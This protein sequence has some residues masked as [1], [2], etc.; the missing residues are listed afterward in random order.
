MV[1]AGLF[2]VG[3]LALHFLLNYHL[4]RVIGRTVRTIIDYKSGGIY[5]MTYHKIRI[6]LL[7]NRLEIRNLRFKPDTARYR[8]RKIH[9]FVKNGLFEI[10]IPQVEIEGINFF[11]ILFH[12]RL[13]IQNFH[14][15][16]PEISLLDYPN[17]R[18]REE[19]L[20]INNLYKF[21]S[22]YLNF[23]KIENLKIENGSFT[24]AYPKNIKKQLCKIDSISLIVRQFKVD[25]THQPQYSAKPFEVADIELAIQRNT[26]LFPESDYQISMGKFLLSTTKTFA[27]LSDIKFKSKEW[28]LAVP[29]LRVVGIDFHTLYYTKNLK[30]SKL[31]IKKPHFQ[32]YQRSTLGQVDISKK[33][34]KFTA[35]KNPYVL[36]SKFL[37]SL[38][39]VHILVEKG[40]FVLNL[41]RITTPKNVSILLERFYLDSLTENQRAKH[42]FIDEVSAQVGDYELLLSDNLHL[43][44]IK[45]MGFSTKTS[46]IYAK[47]V[48]LA[49]T[50]DAQTF[51]LPQQDIFDIAIPE[52]KIKAKN[53][54]DN[55]LT[56]SLVFEELKIKYPQIQVFK[57]INTENITS[58]I[59][60]QLPFYVR[61]ISLENA[62]LQYHQWKKTEEQEHSLDKILHIPNLSAQIYNLKLHEDKYFEHLTLTGENI[63]M[64]LPDLQQHLQIGNIN[65]SSVQQLLRISNFRYFPK[66]VTSKSLGTDSHLPDL[67]LESFDIH[68]FYKERSLKAKK[69]TLQRPSL[70][71]VSKIDTAILAGK[72]AKNLI[73]SIE[74]E[75][76]HLQNA[77]INLHKQSET[78]V[79][80]LFSSDDMSAKLKQVRVNFDTPTKAKS[81]KKLKKEALFDWTL[82]EGEVELNN[83]IFSFPDGSHIIKVKNIVLNYEE[84]TAELK[85]ISLLPTKPKQKDINLYR[86]EIPSIS[87][88][89]KDINHLMEDKNWI[90]NKL[91]I[92]KPQLDFSIQL[93]TAVKH[94][95]Q[96]KIREELKLNNLFAQLP[97]KKL[98][99]NQ[100]D[101]DSSMMVIS[102]KQANRK[103]S[104][105]AVEDFSLSLEHLEVDSAKHHWNQLFDLAHINLK[106]GAYRHFLADNIHQI[107]A[108]N[109][110][111]FSKD[112][113][114]TIHHFSINPIARIGIPYSIEAQ[115]KS[116]QIDI[117]TPYLHFK[118]W[119]LA[120][121]LED[122]ALNLDRA[123]IQTPQINLQVHRP[124]T[125]KK[126]KDFTQKLRA[127]SLHKMIAPFVNNLKIKDLKIINGDLQLITHHFQKTNIFNLDSISIHTQNFDIHPINYQLITQNE[128]NQ[129]LPPPF[130]FDPTPY[131]FLNAENIEIRL[132][133]YTFQLPDKIHTLKAKSIY[134]SIKDSLL[135]AENV[136]FVP[137]LDKNAF[138]KQRQFKT[139]WLFPKIQKLSLHKF[140]FY[141]LLHHEEL[142]MRNLEVDSVKFEIYR[143]RGLP[144]LPDYLPPMP[145]DLLRELPFFVKID[146]IKIKN[147]DI[148]Y[149][150]QLPAKSKAGRL[151]F[152]KTNIDLVSLTNHPDS[153]KSY[154]Y[155]PILKANTY[156]MGQGKLN[157]EARFFMSDPKNLHFLKGNIGEMDMR[158][159]NEMLEYVFPVRITSGFIRN[160][161]F[162]LKLNY[163]HAKGSM[164]L[165]YNDLKVEVI[166]RKFASFVANSFVVTNHNPAR[167]FVPLR[168]GEIKTR[169]N[170][171]RSIFSYWGYSVLNGF[172]TSIG[173]RGKKQ[174]KKTKI[175]KDKKPKQKKLKVR[176]KKQEEKV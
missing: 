159:F 55:L 71:L 31:W 103:T 144:D 21:F 76:V 161:S 88:D 129:V 8:Q 112:S 149:E 97:F 146:S 150:E 16:N 66:Q 143:D 57:K 107:S 48:S 79:Q 47:N 158:A 101:L 170:L 173:L 166:N 10:K 172:K 41:P 125:T 30:I 20:K 18:K 156:V 56:S 52:L 154:L 86:A 140:D 142:K 133:N 113:S 128:A 1:F 110:G 62:D 6:N 127:D 123:V 176:D 65:F 9:N 26:L 61:K 78:Q 75:E 46:E 155:Q 28:E 37:A 162:D 130:I 13:E 95:D 84:S 99:V 36:I 33:E 106:I 44:K 132:K 160:G 108:K 35:L 171:S 63:N 69:L 4:D 64:Y 94:E 90:V 53:L 22:D 148:V 5:K 137:S 124:D 119:D 175:D 7:Q 81:V 145:Q 126:L 11:E 105:L 118:G 167:R 49:L 68:H 50:K 23:F 29:L 24:A 2:L 87:L 139:V 40:E 14:I 117:Y 27:S 54:W 42:F 164:L 82:G 96:N 141:S 116:N 93:P 115:E 163:K 12:E 92:S 135:R 72:P 58:N 80:T 165:R 98:T 67:L 138:S 39:I 120:S 83:Y 109:I 89:I 45:K 91:R 19:R 122:R 74:L 147:A 134:L 100:L 174:Q 60:K 169:R 59:D 136:D 168:T 77:N 17:E 3:L 70:Q 85:G 15:K 102:L 153:L 157:L 121:F 51:A 151:T 73:K 131:Q 38:E 34:T 104:Y 114:L 111:L 43:A 152:E 32:L 25:S